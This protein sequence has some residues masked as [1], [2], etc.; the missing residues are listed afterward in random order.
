MKFKTIPA[1]LVAMCFLGLSV[2]VRA[3]TTVP[4]EKIPSD[5][6]EVVKKEIEA[7]YQ[8][9]FIDRVNATM[10][11]GRMGEEAAP[12]IPFLI[13][14][15][16]DDN[17]EI[18]QTSS[19]LTTIV[20]QAQTAS[21]ALANIGKPAIRPLGD[22]LQH[23]NPKVVDRAARALALMHDLDAVK[24]LMTALNS[25]NADLRST[26]AFRLKESNDARVIKPLLASLEDRSP[27]ILEEAVATLEAISGEKFGQDPQKWQEWWQKEYAKVLQRVEGLI[28]SLQAENVGIRNMVVATL[29]E[30]TGEKFGDDSA[31]WRQ[32]LENQYSK[33]KK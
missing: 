33:Q 26:V 6:P 17:P 8:P 4:R 21:D 28:P 23:D 15:L 9:S 18:V 20:V 30:I 31:K 5:I 16:H 24:V 29:Q 12:A 11:L 3:Q 7:L 19:G 13:G 27:Q 1:L 32:W 25:E 14:L 22:A 10:R 2:G